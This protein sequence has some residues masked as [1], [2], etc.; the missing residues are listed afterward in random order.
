MKLNFTGL[1]AKEMA[2][3]AKIHHQ[4]ILDAITLSNSRSLMKR[5]PCHHSF[6]LSLAILTWAKDNVE[7]Y[8]GLPVYEEMIKKVVSINT[9]YNKIV[10]F[11]EKALFLNAVI[12]IK[13]ELPEVAN[14]AITAIE[15]LGAAVD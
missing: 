3:S 2:E 13:Q 5:R 6:I 10:K 9:I 11:R 12:V 8:K 7:K 14:Q 1:S 4:Q 15:A